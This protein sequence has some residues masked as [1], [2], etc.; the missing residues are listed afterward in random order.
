MRYLRGIIAWIDSLESGSQ[1]RSWTVILLK[2]LGLAVLV[3][4]SAINYCLFHSRRDQ[5]IC[6]Y[7]G[8]PQQYRDEVGG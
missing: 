2:I 1:F 6:K 5:R 8:E 3:W 4:T 7:S